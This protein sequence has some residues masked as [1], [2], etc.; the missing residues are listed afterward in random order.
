MTDRKWNAIAMN[1]DGTHVGP[2]ETINAAAMWASKRLSFNLDK[3][4]VIEHPDSYDEWLA[5]NNNNVVKIG[6]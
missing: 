1:K 5:K 6:E 4:I 2:F 3:F